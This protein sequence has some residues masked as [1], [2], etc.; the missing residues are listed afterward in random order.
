[1]ELVI[2]VRRAPG[3]VRVLRLVADPPR[4]P[5]EPLSKK[6]RSFYLADNS[7]PEVFAPLVD[8]IEV[9]LTHHH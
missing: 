7:F 5:R 6:D 2:P 1:M 8:P 9:S 3:P 4:Q